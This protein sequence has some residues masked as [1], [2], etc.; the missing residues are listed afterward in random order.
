VWNNEHLKF[1]Y[2]IFTIFLA[3]ADYTGL[4]HQSANFITWCLSL[5]IYIWLEPEYIYVVPVFGLLPLATHSKYRNPV[6]NRCWIN[7]CSFY[8]CHQDDTSTCWKQRIP[9]N[10]VRN[11]AHIQ[12]TYR[13]YC[14]TQVFSRFDYVKEFNP[15][16]TIEAYLFWIANWVWCFCKTPFMSKL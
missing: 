12:K 2:N 1:H 6:W 8:K 7:V 14:N 15:C 13:S 3:W 5:K 4:E 11:S 9:S 10:L 16:R